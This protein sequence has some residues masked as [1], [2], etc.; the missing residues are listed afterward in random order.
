[1]SADVT[2]ARLIGTGS[3]A[4]RAAHDFYATDP[5]CVDALLRAEPWLAGQRIWEPAC[6]QGHISKALKRYGCHVTSSDLIERGYGRGGVDFLRT[7][8]LRAPVIVTNPPFSLDVEFVQQALTMGAERV[9]MLL[10]LAFMEGIKRD[11]VIDDCWPLYGASLSRVHVFRNRVALWKNGIPHKGGMLALGW[12][13]WERK[14]VKHMVWD[15][16][17]V[18]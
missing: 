8:V 6:G 10:K 4:Q 1:M 11:P 5:L 15:R 18:R 2:T 17:E 16:L 9:V 13:V 14:R 3:S 7:K 12:F